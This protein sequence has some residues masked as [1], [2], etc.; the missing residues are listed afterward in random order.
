MKALRT[1][2]RTL[3]GHLQACEEELA[4]HGAE[5]KCPVVIEMDQ[6]AKREVKK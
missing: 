2:E 1:F 4:S 5:A 3:R 6:A